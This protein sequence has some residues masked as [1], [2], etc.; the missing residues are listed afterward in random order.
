MNQ[1]SA[2][3]QLDELAFPDNVP[4]TRIDHHLLDLRAFLPSG[5]D[6]K[7]GMNFQFEETSLVVDCQGPQHLWRHRTFAEGHGRHI[8]VEQHCTCPIEHEERVLMLG[9]RDRV[10]QLARTRSSASDRENRVS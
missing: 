7:A 4:E 5:Y 1:C 2:I 10:E 8:E 6:R 9:K 3:R